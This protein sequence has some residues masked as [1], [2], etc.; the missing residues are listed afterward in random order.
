MVCVFLYTWNHASFLNP[1][2][3]LQF[4]FCDYGIGGIKTEF[5]ILMNLLKS[6]LQLQL[7]F[8]NILLG[9]HA[10]GLIQGDSSLVEV[11]DVQIQANR[12]LLLCPGLHLGKEL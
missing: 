2:Y 3:I 5:V 1:N 7:L 4:T 11:P 6:E 10:H 8:K 9:R 12:S